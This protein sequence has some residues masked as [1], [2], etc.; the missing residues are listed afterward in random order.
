MLKAICACMCG[1]V[2]LLAGVAVAREWYEGG[3][4]HSAT[5]E[6][7]CAA[8]PQNRLA[9]AGDW[10]AGTTDPAQL[11]KLGSSELKDAADDVQEC[12]VKGGEGIAEVQQTKALEL[13]V[14]CMAML[15][16]TYPWMLT[17][18]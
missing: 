18:Q 11:R 7:F 5:V 6:K 2:L 10:I 1:M 13:G 12:V 9:T 8:S 14:M 16:K 17:K 15:K 3:T 4:L